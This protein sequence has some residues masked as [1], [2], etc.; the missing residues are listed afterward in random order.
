MNRIKEVG[1]TYRTKVHHYIVD[2]LEKTV[3]FEKVSE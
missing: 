1:K 3:V 2:R